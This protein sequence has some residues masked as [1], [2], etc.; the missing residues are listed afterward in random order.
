MGNGPGRIGETIMR[1]YV[2]AIILVGGGVAILINRIYRMLKGKD[3]CP[4]CGTPWCRPDIDEKN[5][6]QEPK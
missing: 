3:S 4:G 6:E 2:I 1:Y 5:N